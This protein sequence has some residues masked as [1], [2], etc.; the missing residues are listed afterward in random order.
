M[1]QDGGPVAGSCEQSTEISGSEKAG[2]FF[3]I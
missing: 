3:I 1:A 2:N